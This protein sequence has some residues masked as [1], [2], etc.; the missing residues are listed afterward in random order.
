MKL[1]K[2]ILKFTYKFVRSN[3][4]KTIFKKQKIEGLALRISGL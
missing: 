2:M 4:F 1:N 3:S